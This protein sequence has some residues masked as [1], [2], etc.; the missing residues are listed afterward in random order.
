M[1]TLVRPNIH[2]DINN[3]VGDFTSTSLVEINWNN[4]K[5]FVDNIKAVQLRLAED[6]SH[7][8][9]SGVEFIRAMTRYKKWENFLMP[10]VFTSAINAEKNEK[11][12]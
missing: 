10:I 3:I 8:L 12:G 9:Y 2:P 7:N 11:C 6:L 5:N 4:E 1:T